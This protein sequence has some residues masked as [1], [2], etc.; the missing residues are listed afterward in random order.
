MMAD[1]DEVFMATMLQDLKL[2]YFD[3]ML[4][5]LCLNNTY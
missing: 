2:K 4:H 3:N 1:L 5:N